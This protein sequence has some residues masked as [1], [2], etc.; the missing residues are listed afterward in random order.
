[1]LGFVART[2][3]GD[4]GEKYLALKWRCLSSPSNWLASAARLDASARARDRALADM[5]VMALVSFCY[6]RVVAWYTCPTEHASTTR[7][8]WRLQW[9]RYITA[10]VVTES[11]PEGILT[12]SDLE[13]AAVVFMLS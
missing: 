10:A 13:R 9:L 12:N 7:S 3:N 4:F 1:M 11:N 6:G 2:R 8:V 5:I